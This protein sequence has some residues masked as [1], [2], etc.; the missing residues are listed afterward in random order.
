MREILS[1]H[2]VKHL[3]DLFKIV[4]TWHDKHSCHNMHRFKVYDEIQQKVMDTQFNA[5][6]LNLTYYSD[7]S[8]WHESVPLQLSTWKSRFELTFTASSFGHQ[9]STFP[10]NFPSWA[11]PK[12]AQMTASVTPSGQPM[13][14]VKPLL[15][16]VKDG[17]EKGN[18]HHGSK[19]GNDRK[20]LTGESDYWKVA[21]TPMFNIIGKEPTV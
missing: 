11:K 12:S 16:T 15:A 9:V 17:K 10:L 8:N 21:K 7:E 14:N 1:A 13:N 4:T 6:L 2:F 3:S 18:Q 5:F 19:K 20:N